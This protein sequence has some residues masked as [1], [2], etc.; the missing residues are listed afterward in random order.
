MNGHD[1]GVP[2]VVIVAIVFVVQSRVTHSCSLTF[3]VHRYLPVANGWSFKASSLVF[4]VNLSFI[5][6]L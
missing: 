4:L 1:Q 2:I 3:S 5:A 6:M